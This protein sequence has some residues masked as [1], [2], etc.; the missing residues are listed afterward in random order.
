MIKQIA[1]SLVVGAVI[2]ALIH[3]KYAAPVI[4]TKVETKEVEVVRNNIIT[5]TVEVTRPDGT[6][7]VQVVTEDRT[8]RKDTNTVS[9]SVKE[10]K[11]KNWRVLLLT[12]SLPGP[13][14]VYTLG[15]EYRF[16]G[17]LSA[18]G[19]VNTDRQFNIGL[20]YEF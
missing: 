20:S 15:V 2:G 16:L 17:P 1:V 4:E 11:P 7:E 10:V 6:K 9:E 12:N 5:R 19:T 3:A 13:G 14:S 8:V 18:V